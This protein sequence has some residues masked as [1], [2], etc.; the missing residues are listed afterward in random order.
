MPKRPRYEPFPVEKHGKEMW[1]VNFPK[2]DLDPLK[3]VRKDFH[4]KKS[5][6][7]AVREF[8][9]KRNKLGELGNLLRPEDAADA[10]KARNIL[11]PNISLE[12]AATFATQRMEEAELSCTFQEGYTDFLNWCF[13]DHRS[14]R[15]IRDLNQTKKLC[16]PLWEKNLTAISRDE[17]ERILAALPRSSRN[18]KI[19]HLSAVFTHCIRKDWLKENPVRKIQKGKS[20]EKDGPIE[21]FTSEEARKFLYTVA[22]QHPEAIPFFAI[23]F[24]AGTRPEEIGKLTWQ[25]IGE[26]EITIPASVNKTRSERY[27]EINPTLRAWLGW[28]L[29]NGGSNVGRVYPRSQKTLERTRRKIVKESQV[30]WI[31]DGPR[32]TFASAHYR[33][34]QDENM[35]VRAL[36]HKGNTMLHRH[37]NRNIK[38][39]EAVAYWAI[40]PPQF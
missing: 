11:H 8:L 18:L 39:D 37:Y 17:I 1:R 38:G 16:Q 9:S 13:Q 10:V 27:T 5:A 24:F 33:T 30:R 29:A 25:N 36:G 7:K 12:A 26:T 32:K 15:H 40:L 20:K 22:H 35:T 19:S 14:K 6:D 28:H 2:G 23:A 4:S 34:H 31:Q 21:I 3:Q